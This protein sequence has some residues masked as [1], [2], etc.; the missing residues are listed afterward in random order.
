MSQTL[1]QLL[2]GRR[3]VLTDEVLEK[4]LAMLHWQMI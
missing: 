1:I 4:R 3:K 2:L